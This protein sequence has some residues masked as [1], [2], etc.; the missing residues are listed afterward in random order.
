MT[1][2]ESLQHDIGKNNIE[3]RNIVIRSSLIK[4][5]IMNYNYKIQKFSH[6]SPK[7]KKSLQC[8]PRREV[9]YV[10]MCEFTKYE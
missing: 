7:E 5:H 2:D 9:L 8:N 1:F 6:S 3:W 4:V 10:C